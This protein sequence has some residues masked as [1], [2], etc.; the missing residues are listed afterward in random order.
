MLARQRLHKQQIIFTTQLQKNITNKKGESNYVYNGNS[1][2]T[3][4]Y[5]TGSYAK[6]IY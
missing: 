6:R 5:S 3:G 4:F 1:G 2:S